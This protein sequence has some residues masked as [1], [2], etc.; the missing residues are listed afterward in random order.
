MAAEVSVVEVVLPGDGERKE[1]IMTSPSDIFTQEEQ[2]RIRDAV[3]AAEMRTSGEIVPMIIASSSG[4]RRSE[5]LA[6]GAVAM[7]LGLTAGWLFGAGSILWFL[8]VYLIIL[9][10]FLGLMRLCSPLKRLLVH[11]DELTEKVHDRARI[12]F[13]EQGLHE[14]RDRTGI[15][16]LI[17]LFERRVEVLADS[18]I[19]EKVPKDTW[20]GVVNTITKGLREGDACD[21]LVAAIGHCA[22]LLTEHFPRKDDDSNELPDLILGEKKVP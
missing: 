22:N 9:F 1:V 2:D 13:L 14:T 4:Y 18:G 16:I 17:S 11:P 10:A 12:I 19:N 5:Y 20:N 3:K 7:A 15:L 21:S 6:A 8:P